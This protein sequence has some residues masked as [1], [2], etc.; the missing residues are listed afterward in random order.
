MLIDSEVWWILFATERGGGAHCVNE[1]TRID[2][3]Q[4]YHS[5]TPEQIARRAT[6]AKT[7]TTVTH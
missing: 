5:H 2:C 3:S 7:P 4:H 1:Y 6:A